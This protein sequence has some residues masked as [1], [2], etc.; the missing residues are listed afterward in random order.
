MA[1]TMTML[2]GT[3]TVGLR[4]TYRLIFIVLLTSR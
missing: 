4:D 1:S 2:V 3:Y